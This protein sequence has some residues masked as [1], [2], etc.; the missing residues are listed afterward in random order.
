M[1]LNKPINN[2]T[3]VELQD[4][5]DEAERESRFLEYKKELNLENEHTKA[6]FRRDVSSFANALGG[7][8]IIGISEHGDTKLPKEL[9]GFELSAAN[10]E[11][12]SVKL[13]KVLQSRIKP[14]IRGIGVELIELSS[15]KYA[16]VIRI[17]GSFAKPHQ[18]DGDPPNKPFEFWVRIDGAKERMDIDELRDSVLARDEFTQRSSEFSERRTRD[19]A[20]GILMAD[21]KDGAKVLLHL[22]PIDA[23][24]GSHSLELSVAELGRTGTG[25]VIEWPRFLNSGRSF[26]NF[27]GL[28]NCNVNVTG[29]IYAAGNYYCHFFRNGILEAVENYCL[30]DDDKS[31]PITNLQHSL[32]ERV[33]KLYVIMQQVG[34]VPPV[35]VMIRLVGVQGFRI[36]HD[37]SQYQIQT[38]TEV[39]RDHLLLPTV[40][41]SDTQLDYHS[42]GQLLRPVFDVIWQ[43]CNYRAC[44]YYDDAGNYDDNLMSQK[45]RRVFM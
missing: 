40:V 17:P 16:A 34:V 5:I 30:R 13:T 6:E 19:I 36:V 26:Y 31:I 33:E 4:L 37:S 1:P 11:Q 8:I 2:I 9:C 24:R 38:A 27:D 32:I 22:V 23:F 29:P 10:K 43:S 20:A 42:I 25:R 12:F 39:D 28:V 21:L 3:E 44:P 35:A 14:I 45:L 41:L 7:D 15:G 18:V